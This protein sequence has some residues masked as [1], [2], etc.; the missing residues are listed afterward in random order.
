MHSYENKL[1]RRFKESILTRVDINKVYDKKSSLANLPGFSFSAL[2]SL[3]KCS[4]HQK[5]GQR[6][7]EQ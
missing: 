4:T 3:E 2:N 5:Q 7:K 6:V 1:N